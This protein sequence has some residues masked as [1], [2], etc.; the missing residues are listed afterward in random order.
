MR[1]ETDVLPAPITYSHCLVQRQ[2][3]VLRAVS[4]IGYV[5][6]QKLQRLHT[7]MASLL[8]LMQLFFQLNIDSISQND[9]VEAVM[10]TII[11][12]FFLLFY[13]KRD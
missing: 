4:L 8:V 9:L 6:M 1:N 7:K 5:Q 2:A 11:S 12:R 3:E 10:E 13:L